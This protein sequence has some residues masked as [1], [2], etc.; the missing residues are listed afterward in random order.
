[1]NARLNAN[2]LSP[3]EGEDVRARVEAMPLA[4]LVELAQSLQDGGQPDLADRVYT[5][6]L[7][8]SSHPLRYMAL[9]NHGAILQATGQADRAVHAYRQCM[10]LSPGFGQAYINLGL[11]YEKLGQEGIALEVW[12]QYVGQRFVHSKD[13][14]QL[15]CTALNHIGRVHEGRKHYAL[16]ERALEQ[17]LALDPKQAGVIQHWVHI[18]QKA[19]QWPVYKP[20]PGISRSEMLRCTSP[21]AMLAL[22]DDPVMQLLTAQSFVGRTYPVQQETLHDPRRASGSQ[23]RVGIVSGDLREHAVGFL[24]EAFVRGLDRQQYALHAYDF[25][26]EED[27]PTR[28]N[29]KA[30]F[31]AMT[32]ISAMTD[33]QAAECIARDGIDVLIDLHGLSAG[34]RPGIFALHPA[35]RQLTYLGYMG[36]T[37]MPWFDHVIVDPVALPEAL[38]HAFME[39]PIY[40]SG[41]YIPLTLEKPRLPAASRAQQ[42]LP[43]PA[44]VMAAFGNVYKITEEMFACWMRLL[45]R[46]RH[47]VL[48]LIDDN[49]VTTANLRRAAREQGI[50]ESRLVFMSRCVHEEFCA[51]LKL[52][53]VYLDTYPY[54]CGSTSNDVINAGVPLVSLY[55]KTLVSRMG[56]SILSEVGQAELAVDSFQKYEEKVLEL[57]LKSQADM[58]YVFA[59][60][61]SSKL[62]SVLDQLRY[63]RH[64]VGMLKLKVDESIQRYEITEIASHRSQ[65]KS[66]PVPSDWAMRPAL[67]DQLLHSRL[68]RNTLYGYLTPDF[69]A[70]T[71]LA[72]EDIERRLLSPAP[73]ADVVVLTSDF[74]SDG[75]FLNPFMAVGN[76]SPEWLALAQSFCDHVGLSLDLKKWVLPCESTVHGLACVARPPV[77]FDWLALAV[78]LNDFSKGQWKE[79]LASQVVWRG[80]EFSSVEL[81]FDL[82]MNLAVVRGDRTVQFSAHIETPL[83]HSATA[84]AM[85]WAYLRTR[86]AGYLHGFRSGQWCPEGIF[87]G[88]KR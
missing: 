63:G 23:W 74:E 86:Q 48:W 1:M 43:E 27:T 26:R 39:K 70:R 76:T 52:A 15:H 17:S 29:L 56:L 32:D 8:A 55:G 59:S 72:R 65:P 7:A 68:D 47:A 73:P 69:Y 54:N 83:T 80:R 85:K 44:F 24:V 77:W 38:S 51:R 42:G 41:S 2:A 18:R 37:A 71:G 28:R 35:P 36:S 20:L 16:A 22:V 6:W 14:T 45:K 64:A 25:S 10:T 3:N 75:A 82:L 49:E 57:S 31:D 30:V 46:I 79:A 58:R 61:G 19:C 60:N 4:E 33:R 88:N 9:F 13:D 66:A 84:N 53:D 12:G 11:L 34:A 5:V 50:E 78:E 62:Q 81:L 67:Q 87:Q 21:L 40:V